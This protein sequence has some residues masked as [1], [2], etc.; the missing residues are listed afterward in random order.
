MGSDEDPCSFA[1]YLDEVALFCPHYFL[2]PALFTSTATRSPAPAPAGRWPNELPLKAILGERPE[3][4]GC[5]PSP[6]G[7]SQETL[8][9]SELGRL[10]GFPCGL[11]Q[12]RPRSLSYSDS[13]VN[14]NLRD[15]FLAPWS[16]GFWRGDQG[17]VSL[18]CGD[19]GCRLT[20]DS[21]QSEAACAVVKPHHVPYM[22]Y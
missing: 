8:P 5:L 2:T 20:R 11:A 6:S 15:T 18:R 3:R 10:S 13:W 21:V 22:F 7:A 9:A 17:F 4:A 19:F 14:P 12:I 1:G 16:A